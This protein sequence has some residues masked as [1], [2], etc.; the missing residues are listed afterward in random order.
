MT[1]T[2]QA[3]MMA[4]LRVV[5]LWAV[6]LLPVPVARAQESPR[7]RTDVPVQRV[8]LFSSGVGYFEHAG[9]VRDEVATELRFKTSQIND[10]LKSLVIQDQDGGKIGAITYASQDP[11]EKTLRS[12]QV[13]ITQNP[14]LAELL[15]QLRG[16]RVTVVTP[17]E[18]IS[19]T[20]LGVETRHRNEASG[21]PI[22]TT[23]VAVLNLLSGASIRSLALPS[24]SSFSL[25]DPELQDELRRALLALSQ[26]RDQ[27][28]KPV[29]INFSGVGDRRVRIGYVVETPIWKTSYRLLLDKTASRLQGWAIVENQTESD[30]N[31]VALSLVSGRPISFSMDLYQP[32]YATRPVVTQELFEGLRPRVYE[33]GIDERRARESPGSTPPSR[34]FSGRGVAGGSARGPERAMSPLALNAVVVSNPPLIES[35]ASAARMG[36]LF[37]YTV[38]S[39]SLARQKSAMLPIVADSITAER[40]SIF[41]ASVLPNHPLNGVRVTNTTGKHLLQGPVTVLDGGGYAGDAQ[42][43]NL[44]PGQQRLLSFGIDLDLRVN[45]GISSRNSVVLTGRIA[46]GLLFVDQKNVSVR[47]YQ[48]DNRS[49]KAKV[50]ITEHPITAGASLVGT[51]KPVE[52]TDSTY[53]FQ[54]TVA[55]NAVTLLTVREE[56]VWTQSMSIVSSD[57]MQLEAFA[58]GDAIPRTVRDAILK[59]ASLK[60][61]MSQ[62]DRQI[63]EQM[64]QQNDIDQEQ[65]RLRENM[66]TV[67]QNSEYYQ[68]LLEKLNTQE[69]L[70]ESLQRSRAELQLKREGQQ[71]E[72]DAFVS[73]QEV[74]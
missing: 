63:A 1:S 48:V 62:T 38:N 51:Q 9:R 35:V 3:L 53:R 72:F 26:A 56:Q 4:R 36:E 19:G 65:I 13:D 46:R 60:A 64:K 68:R 73:A 47:E 20:V 69:S 45:A 37:Q 67:A 34:D 22:A 61:A 24:V 44:P 40:V 30:W 42:I 16:A 33:S 11:L 50:L 15:N 59:V 54:S 41:N 32:L 17:T 7:A 49:G 27:D 31:D 2:K 6:P 5:L 28:K 70:I 8:M 57:L 39:V 21:Q 14:S 55:A 25:D 43:D 10:I 29:T 12:F 52:T 23:A 74:G 66:K 18:R 58:R 71:R